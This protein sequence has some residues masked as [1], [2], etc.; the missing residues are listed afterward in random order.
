MQSRIKHVLHYK[1]P[2]LWVINLALITV[3]AAGTALATD[4]NAKMAGG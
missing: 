4:R 1:K 3:L 2:A